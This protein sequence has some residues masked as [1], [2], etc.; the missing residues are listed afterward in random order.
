MQSNGKRLRVQHMDGDMAGNAF[1]ASMS[2]FARLAGDVLRYR[3]ATGDV[4]RAFG[5]EQGE[6][7]YITQV[8]TDQTVGVF[9]TKLVGD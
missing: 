9:V 4:P 3:V 1:L 7:D 8:N 6:G 5:I 2:G